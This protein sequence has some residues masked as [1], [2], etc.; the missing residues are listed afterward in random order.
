M[1]DKERLIAYLYDDLSAAERTAFDAHLA[2]CAECRAEAAQLQRTRQH[3][4]AWAP[5]EPA[6]NFRV[7]RGTQ[8]AAPRRTLAFVPQ[9]ALAAA[10]GI[11]LLAGAAAIANVEVRYGADGVVVRTGW[12]SGS[13]GE[14]ASAAVVPDARA[15]PAAAAVASSEQAGR[16]EAEIATLT[17]RLADL[18]A[19][20]G[21]RSV[22]AASVRPGISAV[23]LRKILAEN[24]S[25]QRTEMA[26]QIAQIWKDFNA[27]RA[28][29]FVRVQQTLAPELQRQRH[30]IENLYRVSL[31]K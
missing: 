6:F 2:G 16:L 11:L 25:R 22:S 13:P 30:S 24:E 4:T 8:E 5:P 20:Q 9:W 21:T 29:D 14:P 15:L 12:A 18:E 23:E 3:L 26:L 19:A 7:V 17:K 31:Q 10:A 28:S 1:C 27:A